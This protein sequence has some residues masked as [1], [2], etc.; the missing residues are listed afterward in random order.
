MMVGKI[1]PC[2]AICWMM[3]TPDPLSNHWLIFIGCA[4]VD[5]FATLETSQT[6]T[7]SLHTI[8]KPC[9]MLISLSCLVV[10]LLC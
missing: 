5:I 3:F 1:P 7:S 9:N 6:M 4:A 8:D 10:K 2:A